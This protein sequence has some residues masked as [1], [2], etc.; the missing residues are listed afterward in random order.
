MCKSQL[1]TNIFKR[2]R[3]T[4]FRLRWALGVFKERGQEASYLSIKTT[5]KMHYVDNLPK[6]IHKSCE[7][8]EKGHKHGLA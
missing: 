4:F 7:K 6:N 1:S 5:L 8:G 3:W 2:F